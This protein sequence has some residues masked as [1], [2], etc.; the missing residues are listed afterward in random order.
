MLL[1]PCC[2][3]SRPFLTYLPS[4]S[5]S[6]ILWLPPRIWFA[7]VYVASLSS[8]ER[9]TK[10]SFSCAHG[11]QQFEHHFMKVAR[12]PPLA[13]ASRNGGPPPFSARPT[14]A[15]LGGAKTGEKCGANVPMLQ[16]R[17]EISLPRALLVPEGVPRAPSL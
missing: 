6:H 12:A 11:E 3:Y 15:F 17:T 16:A 4:R 10:A 1:D 9:T 2:S 13:L 5:N 7:S 14:F 8:S